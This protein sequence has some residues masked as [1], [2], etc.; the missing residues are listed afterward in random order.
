MKE[1]RRRARQNRRNPTRSEQ[2]LWSALR[3]RQLAGY[4]F[5]RQNPLA[6]SVLDFYCPAVKLAVEVDGGVH[7]CSRQLTVDRARDARLTAMG[8][9][10]LHFQTFEVMQNLDKVL[11]LIENRCRSLGPPKPPHSSK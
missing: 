11:N 8:I 7:D 6:D 10:V 3:R 4:K 1:L 5:R 9:T 2:R